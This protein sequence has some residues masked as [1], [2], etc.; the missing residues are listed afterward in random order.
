MDGLLILD[1]LVDRNVRRMRD[2][3]M[4]SGRDTAM[5]N[6]KL[7]RDGKF[8]EVWPD[9]FSE[10][11][12]TAI[13]AN[14]VDVATR[15]IAS[16]LAP[17][18]SLACSAG[19]MRTNADKTRAE[20]KNRIGSNYWRQSQLD[21][22]M[23]TGA[24]Q[25]LSYGFLPFWVEAD[26]AR[27]T[28]V[29]HVEDPEGAYY[30]LDRWLNTIRYAKV[31]TWDLAEFAAQFPE[32]VRMALLF[33]DDG[34]GGKRAVSLQQVEVVRYTDDTYTT[35]YCPSRN[36]IVVARYAH[37][38]VMN[39]KPACPVRIALRPGISNN[40]RGQFDDVL[41]VQL[42]HSVMAALTLEAGHK[43]VEAPIVLP[44]DVTQFN[45]G[46]DAVIQSDNGDK[47]HRVPLEVPTA[48][49]QLS[50]QLQN[51]M[52]SGAGYPTTRQ[53]DPGKA[54]VT[55]RGI[56]ALEGGFDS[57]ISLGQTVLG[58][59]LREV[60]KMCFRLDA[61]LW[62]KATKTIRGT[63][64]GMTFEVSYRPGVDLAD[65]VECEVTY[66]FAAGSS[67]SNAIVT[68]LQLQGGDIISKDTFRRQLP[69]DIDIDEQHRQIDIQKVED[70][71]MQGLAA[72]L[73]SVGQLMAAG[74]AAQANQIIQAAAIIAEGR[75]KG[76]SLVD[77]YLK[78]FPA[79]APP[80]EAAP[81]MTDPTD[82]N[83]PPP[84]DSAG[85]PQ[86]PGGEPTPG[87]Q[88]SGLPEGVAPGQGG[89]APGGRPSLSNLAAGIGS[90]GNAKMSDTIQRKLPI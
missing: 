44:T 21:V 85:G 65:D 81:G 33:E 27:K 17:L 20:K 59:A 18:P 38:M 28:P 74:Q 73:T 71:M 50:A 76:E 46:A 43:A 90:G 4:I 29:I 31:S 24:D 39:G 26:F 57:Q 64:S 58:V 25:Y 52:N 10:R 42:A 48:A 63:L 83:A 87:V 34:R 62:P 84:D 78:A 37:K 32:N 47:I 5:S 35:M 53:G 51:E 1:P 16:N 70:A 86:G 67:P 49:F 66:G 3:A 11:Y 19:A 30:E 82:P 80:P 9:Q 40:P 69:F 68:L 22:M 89:M 15:D 2:L 12:P 77:L 8:S 54:N 75:A 88:Q 6:V 79:P 55:G 14:F 13:V 23:N 7:V 61:I 56:S 45:V 72:A 60:T 36:N 41:W